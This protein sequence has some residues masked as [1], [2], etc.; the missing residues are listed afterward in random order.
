MDIPTAFEQFKKPGD[1]NYIPY[2]SQVLIRFWGRLAKVLNNGI[3]M[4]TYADKAGAS[5]Q[6]INGNVHGY[7]WT[8]NLAIGAN[9]ITH[10][11][12]YVPLGFVILN[13]NVNTNLWHTGGT[14]TTIIVNSSAACTVNL[15]II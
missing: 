14:T 3:E 5:G 11:L 10:P 8:G 7:V 6:P 2:L 13:V 1:K 12:K 4:Y 15:L 9:T